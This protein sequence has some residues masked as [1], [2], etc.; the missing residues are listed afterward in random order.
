LQV[1]FRRAFQLFEQP[2]EIRWAYHWIS[3]PGERVNLFANQLLY[4]PFNEEAT[5]IV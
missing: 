4:E 3:R 2:Q 1:V 5:L